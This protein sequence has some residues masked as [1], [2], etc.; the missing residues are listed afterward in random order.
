MLVDNLLRGC[1]AN[2]RAVVAASTAASLRAVDLRCSKAIGVGTIGF[3][4]WDVGFAQAL[5]Y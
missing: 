1:Q 2:T 4:D 5:R 3:E